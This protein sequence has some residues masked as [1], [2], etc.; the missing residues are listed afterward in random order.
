LMDYGIRSDII[1]E[2]Y[3]AEAVA[4]AF[5]KENVKDK[6]ILLPRA[7]LARPVL[8]VELRKMGA[9]VDEITAYRTVLEK[10]NKGTL[11]QYLEEKTA[12]MVTFTSSSTVTNFK[13]LLPEGSVNQLMEGVTVACIGPITA[14]TAQK[15]GFHVDI[16]AEDY[17]IDGLCDAI[18]KRFG[19]NLS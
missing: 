11:K 14:K 15:L 18:L 9:Q 6:R 17:T 5:E 8:P 3:V 16:V 19:N 4:A 13:S 2:S 10:H 1:P 7:E 12:D